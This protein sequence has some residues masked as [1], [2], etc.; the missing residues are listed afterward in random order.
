MPG[1]VKF[2]WK[3]HDEDIEMKMKTVAMVFAA[4]GFLTG[5]IFTGIAVSLSAGR[6]M[7]TEFRSPYDYEKTVELIKT[8]INLQPGWHVVAV[9]D[10]NKEVMEHGGFPIG[11]FA[12]IKYC[13]GLIASQMLQDDGRKKMG[14]M[15]PKAF[16]VYEKSEGQVYVSS[17]NG[18][19]MGKL[20]GGEAERIIERVSLDVEGMLRFMNFKFPVF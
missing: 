5:M 19:V 4:I 9:Y 3:K 2:A 17:P 8:R 7:I 20:F 14:S 16:A 10:Q 18:A 6:M 15:M 1:G 13:N 11:K 12:I